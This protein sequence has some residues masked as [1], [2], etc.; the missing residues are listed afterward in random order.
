VAREVAN[1]GITVNA[2]APGY[3]ST[4]ITE[5]LSEEV[6]AK[7]L[8]NIPVARFGTPED[9]ADV[10]VFLASEGARYITGQV[11]NVDGGMVTA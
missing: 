11:I 1:R 8:D 4:D 5:V 2:V 6:K 9:V 3:I 7:V 10:V